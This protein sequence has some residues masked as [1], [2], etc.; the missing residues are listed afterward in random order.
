MSTFDFQSETGA[1]SPT[2]FQDLLAIRIVIILS[3]SM[4]KFSL[5][6]ITWTSLLKALD[7]IHVMQTW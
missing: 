7:L 5:P 1:A 3:H 4:Y 2:K 6:I